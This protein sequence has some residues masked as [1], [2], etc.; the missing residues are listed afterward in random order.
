MRKCREI[1][2]GELQRQKSGKATEKS[3]AKDFQCTCVGFVKAYPIDVLTS[4]LVILSF[5]PQGSE[6]HMV[7][8]SNPPGII[9]LLRIIVAWQQGLK[10]LVCVD[11]CG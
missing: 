9:V 11:I 8:S 4:S 1:R 10:S 7:W 2:R 6:G 3:R 5:L